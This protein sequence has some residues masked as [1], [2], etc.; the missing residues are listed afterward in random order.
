MVKT[1]IKRTHDELEAK[2]AAA[3]KEKTSAR[4]AKEP[5]DPVTVAKRERDAQLR[6]LTD[7]AHGAN[8]DLGHALIHKLT[9]V[10]PTDITVAKFFVLCGRRHSTNYADRVTMPISRRRM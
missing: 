6:E 8:T 1:A 4:S 7:E 5:A 10:D 9:T 3:A 2:A